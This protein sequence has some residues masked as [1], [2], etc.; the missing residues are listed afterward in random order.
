[1]SVVSDS[2]QIWDKVL[3]LVAGVRD[4]LHLRRG[5]QVDPGSQEVFRL[6][7]RFLFLLLRHLPDHLP[8]DK[9]QS[10]SKMGENDT[11][12]IDYLTN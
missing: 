11:I 4:E 1:M 2:W 7:T 5:G 10:G 6:R 3:N 12:E 9:A 8:T